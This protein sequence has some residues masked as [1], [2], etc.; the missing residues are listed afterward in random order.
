MDKYMNLSKI[1]ILVVVFLISTSLYAKNRASGFAI[2]G[3]VL[4]N[5]MTQFNLSGVIRDYNNVAIDGVTISATGLS[6]TQNLSDGSYQITVP[7]GWSGTVTPSKPGWVLTPAQNTSSTY[8]NVTSDLSN[9]NIS[10]KLAPPALTPNQ[11]TYPTAQSISLNSLATGNVRFRYTISPSPVSYSSGLI[12]DNRYPI[13]IAED[14]TINAVTYILGRPGSVSD[15]VSATYH[16]GQEQTSRIRFQLEYEAQPIGNVT[17]VDL[18]AKG[19]ASRYARAEVI[20]NQVDFTSVDLFASLFSF[21]GTSETSDLILRDS[22]LEDIGHIPFNY[23]QA[24]WL[25][26]LK[27]DG[28]LMVHEPH[29]PIAT[30]FGRKWN[31][32]YTPEERM[33]SMLIKPASISAARK[34]MILVHGINGTYPYFSKDFISKLDGNPNTNADD[35]FD[36][37]QFYYPYD[38]QIELSGNLLGDAIQRVHTYGYNER[39]NIVAHS[40]G[41][42]VTRSL[43]QSPDY[44]HNIR[45]FLML[46][47]PNHGSHS[48]FRLS[49]HGDYPSSTL[50]N[51]I[52]VGTDTD[53]P[54][55]KQLYPGS[56]FLTNLNSQVP[57]ELYPGAPKANTYLVVAGTTNEAHWLS[58]S[59]EILSPSYMDDMVVSLPSA[60]LLDGGI[61]LATVP[62]NHLGL[63]G[64]TPMGI[65]LLFPKMNPGYLY[66]F[67]SDDYQTSS[68]PFGASVTNYWNTTS[69]Q[70]PQASN[71]N[72][73]FGAMLN[74]DCINVERSGMTLKLKFTD[75]ESSINDIERGTKNRLIK[76]ESD[77]YS[78]KSYYFME[79]VKTLLG[80]ATGS[81]L[82]GDFPTG[83]Y[84]LRL[85]NRKSKTFKTVQNS[86]P[87]NNA[88]SSSIFIS[89]TPGEKAI[90]NLTNSTLYSQSSKMRD[91]SNRTLTEE[92][93]Y[94]DASID[95]LV[96]Y[97]GGE[98]GIAGFAQHNAHLIDP[99]N[100]MIDQNY[101]SV[102]PNVDFSEDIEAGFAYYYVRNPLPGLWK[103]RYSD[104]L[105][106]TLST[107]MINSPITISA[108]V[109]DTVF[110]IGETVT[111]H[112]PLPKPVTYTNPQI[113]ISL[114]YLDLD[115]VTHSLGSLVASYNPLDSLYQCSFVP[116]FPGDYKLSINFLCT[117]DG[118]D[119][120]RIIENVIP[121][122]AHKIPLTLAPQIGEGNLPTSLSLQWNSSTLAQSYQLKL[123]AVSDSLAI[124]STTVNDTAYV[125]SNLEYGKEYYWYVSA[126]NGYGTSQTSN[127]SN[128]FT[129]LP[130]PVLQNPINAEI[131]LPQ[132]VNL[133]WQAVPGALQYHLQLSDD[134]LFNFFFINDSL[135]TANTYELNGLANLET[136]YWRVAS[137][138]ER[139]ASDWSE[140]RSFTIRDYMISFPQTVQMNENEALT[141]YLHSYIDDFSSGQF[142]IT[143]SGL[144]NL[145]ATVSHDR[146]VITPVENWFGT[147]DIVLTVSDLTRVPSKS[148]NTFSSRIP[149]R[150]VVYQATIS[151]VVTE[152]NSLPT[153]T[154]GE[155]LLFWDSE[156]KVL[157]LTPYLSDPDNPI[158]E[159]QITGIASTHIGIS[160][161]GQSITLLPQPGWFGQELIEIQLSNGMPRAIVKASD[162]KSVGR[163]EN[164]H[165]SYYMLVNIVDAAPVISDWSVASNALNLFWEPITGA[166]T[167]RV[168]SSDTVNG[169][170]TDV[171]S[172][173]SLTLQNGEMKWQ[174]ITT[175]A[176]AFYYIKATKGSRTMTSKPIFS[177]K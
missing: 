94:I 71:T 44:Q 166:D 106:D 38:Q 29:T 131:N 142:D 74:S 47:T 48:T 108:I 65:P 5:T 132:T 9:L 39:I 16:I 122:V 43:I 27:V 45:K 51:S 95:S 49:H 61:P 102:S 34:P 55:V 31:Y 66:S 76:A 99:E 52:F 154:M 18:V 7:R 120:Q 77:G 3:P 114:N 53:S 161:N 68:N 139:G 155:N 152:Q 157:N 119:I 151:V 146:I 103:L 58:T 60:S 42:L 70:S 138:D 136:Y 167:Y 32:Y 63:C 140:V 171:T 33:V 149:S 12:Y 176:R 90:A 123:F 100:T 116:E 126:V 36:I 22:Q 46:G 10:G 35:I 101:A 20:N 135:L 137:A 69:V 23:T 118:S 113:S 24:N 150:T 13:A 112:I 170:F 17:Y 19:L 105:P 168:F 57:N 93:Y 104:S 88:I 1:L 162:K 143:L 6:D 92:Q 89:L 141:L 144:T 30:S 147:D 159:I 158:G 81:G 134:P 21:I 73:Q 26:G 130:Q 107:T 153:L 127:P 172:S 85:Q 117:L 91:S 177:N 54:A 97:I 173:G 28:I 79:Q 40:M 121:V 174:Q 145:T 15:M 82:T 160:I 87:I 41:G 111:V 110:A 164:N 67:F 80:M 25:T 175:A 72:V 11:G 86:L 83:N 4:V 148:N 125:V 14:A 75:Y 37:W 156:D 115:S 59:R 50:V 84:S 109:A 96:F 2:Y 124:V 169:V 128:F 62:V 8:S 64:N 133:A 129:K 56:A 78:N 98:E 165:T 163:T